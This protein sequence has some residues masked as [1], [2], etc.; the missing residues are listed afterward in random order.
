[1]DQSEIINILEE[2]CIKLK[3]IFYSLFY[4]EVIKTASVSDKRM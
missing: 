3:V 1:M 4:K 2:Y